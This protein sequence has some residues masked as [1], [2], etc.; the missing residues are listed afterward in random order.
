MILDTENQNHYQT[1]NIADSASPEMVEMAFNQLLKDA[2]EKLQDSPIYFEKEKLLKEAYAILSN[3]ELRQAYDIKLVRDR[4]AKSKPKD[5]PPETLNTSQTVAK[6][7]NSKGF[8]AL[9]VAVIVGLFLLPSGKDRVENDTANR[10]LDNSYDIQSQRL[11]L[12]RDREQRFSSSDQR[13]LDLQSEREAAKISREE[14]R[15]QMAE[16]RE[17]RRIEKELRWEDE[18]RQRKKEY[19]RKQHSKNLI[20]QANKSDYKRYNNNYRNN[21]NSGTLGR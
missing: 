6:L 1:L 14:R 7:L 12:E 16:E 17:T 8:I 18:R 5:I 20:R 3:A 9:V 15:L 4:A 19:E 2:K 21:G 13:R 10:R 11:D